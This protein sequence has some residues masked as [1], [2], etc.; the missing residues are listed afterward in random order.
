MTD[1]KWVKLKVGMFDGNSFKRIK[2]AKIGG[3]SYRDKLTAVWFEL[4]DF[5]GKCNHGGAFI[6]SHEIPFT[7]L[8]DIATMIDREPDELKLCMTFYVREGMVEIIDDVYQLTNWTQYQN[9]DGLAKIREKKRLAQAK[10]R[11]KKKGLPDG[12]SESPSDP[13]DPGE[14]E[15]LEENGEIVDDVERD[16]DST[17]NLPSISISNISISN[18]SN[19]KD[20]ED[21]K[22]ED[23]K[24]SKKESK[25]SS[26]KTEPKPVEQPPFDFSTVNFSPV[27]VS[28]VQ[29]WLMYK[30]ERR[31]AYK[32][33]G[34]QSLMTK[35]QNEA[36]KYGEQAVIKIITD[37]MASNYQG[38]VW[39]RL[40][41]KN[42]G[43]RNGTPA[44]RVG[45]GPAIGKEF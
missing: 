38:I 41:N 14:L 44:G 5:S 26:K 16:V 6:D 35:I 4:L 31:E 17:N 21:I 24:E 19:T 12:N 28:T 42:G 39:D 45:N 15:N 1:V 30:T 34:L 13:E 22:K 2:R 9:E 11:A 37:S 36:E 8:D 3:E 27:M 23:K 40:G 20:I 18:I 33:T 7:D 25:K 10:W 29:K 32:P 43:G